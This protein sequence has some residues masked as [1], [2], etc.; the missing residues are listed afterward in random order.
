MA[1]QT[2]NPQSFPPGSSREF[3]DL[4]VRLQ[5]FVDNTGKTATGAQE[6]A[7][8]AQQ[9]AD[10]Q[11]TRNDSQDQTLDDH[12]SEINTAQGDIS[13][14][15]DVITNDVI[16][17]DRAQLQVMAGPLSVGTEL[18]ISNVKVLGGRITG[19]TASTGTVSRAGL[20]ADQAFTVGA[21]YSQT[22]MQAIAAAL[23]EV[24]KLAAALQAAGTSH[25]M[26]G[27]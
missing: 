19:W 20:N 3:I 2:L 25:G 13:A 27:T 22:E 1:G 6:A 12:Q 24:R 8:G 21:A 11:A 23:V 17:N 16:H 5:Q 4:I 14:L 26:I 9:T 7:Q 18:R 10:Q 15:T